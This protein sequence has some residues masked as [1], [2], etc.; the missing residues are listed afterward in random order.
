MPVTRD[1]LA[2]YGTRVKIVKFY[3]PN[4][5]IVRGEKA[6]LC[7]GVVN[8]KE[9]RLEPT[10]EKVW[11]A[12]SRCFDVAPRDTTRYTLTAQGKDQKVDSASLEIAVRQ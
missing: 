11:P 8:A 9:V 1:P 4:G 10:I 6:L 12:L 2:Q 3:A 7:Y 5:T